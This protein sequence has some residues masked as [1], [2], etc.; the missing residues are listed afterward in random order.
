MNFYAALEAEQ[1][2][3]LTNKIV[4]EIIQEPSR[5]KEIIDLI[6]D[7]PY[8]ITQR[9]AWPLSVVAEKHPEL[10][11]PYLPILVKKLEE[12]G[13][14]P[15]VNRNIVRALQYIR[16]PEDLEGTVLNN[17]FNLLNS[18][19]EPLA[20]RCFSMTVIHNLVD[21]YPDIKHELASSITAQLPHQ[22]A[23]FRSRGTKILKALGSLT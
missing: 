15:A 11:V 6:M 19:D 14:H 12:K 5:M 10:L 16:V 3:A 7:A 4:G 8:R 1:S 17:C 2:K 21:K 23:G 18:R 22:T 13:N 9:A 20:V